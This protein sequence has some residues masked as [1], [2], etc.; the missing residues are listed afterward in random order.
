[1]YPNPAKELL[2]FN[3]NIKDEYN[4]AEFSIFNLTGSVVYDSK[5]TAQTGKVSIKLD[6][7]PGGVYFYKVII[8]GRIDK[9]EKLVIIK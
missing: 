4:N 1:L 8:D 7:L 3:Y 9:T 6:K 5:L 2:N